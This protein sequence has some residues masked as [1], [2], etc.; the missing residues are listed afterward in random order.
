MAPDR[1]FYRPHSDY[2]EI[3]DGDPY[4]TVFGERQTVANER[5]R[6]WQKQFEK[7]NADVLLP[8]ERDTFLKRLMPNWAIVKLQ[9]VQRYGPQRMWPLFAFMG[10]TLYFVHWWHTQEFHGDYRDV[11]EVR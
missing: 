2:R 10:G 8:Y 6:E 9:R 3:Q 1:R 11:R 4:S 5:L 7:E